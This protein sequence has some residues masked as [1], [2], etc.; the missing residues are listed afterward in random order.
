MRFTV[1]YA[2]LA[3]TTATAIG[4]AQHAPNVNERALEGPT[5]GP[6]YCYSVSSENAPASYLSAWLT[7]L[8]FALV[9]VNGLINN[10]QMFTNDDS[11]S[12]QA[13]ASG[14][15]T[16]SVNL[17]I[18]NNAD[19][20]PSDPIAISNTLTTL[21]NIVAERG[22]VPMHM[23]AS[24]ARDGADDNDSVGVVIDVALFENNGHD[25]LR[26]LKSR[27]IGPLPGQNYKDYCTAE[28]NNDFDEY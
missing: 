20:Q 11:T 5:Q 21:R 26:R 24:T 25:E 15:S 17:A 23:A 18:S 14:D 9:T 3:T 27:D 19:G 10:Q 2:L 12:W 28:A 8:S 1:L 22:A 4:R 13:D 6:G 16:R 7:V